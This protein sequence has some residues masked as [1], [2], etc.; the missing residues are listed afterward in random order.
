MTHKKEDRRV[1]R[2]RQLLREALISLILE[3]RYETI[4]V[5]DILD[6]ANVGRSTFYA[7]FP[8]KEALL[9]SSFYE[10]GQDLHAH[11]I[12]E[13]EQLKE[14]EGISCLHLFRHAESNY[15]LYKAMMGGKGIDVVVETGTEYM[16]IYL[17]E[18]IKPLTGN[19]E[20]QVP[21][22]V[23]IKYLTG[24]LMSLLR[25]WL[26]ND[27]P[28][29]PEKMDEMFQQIAMPGVWNVLEVGSKE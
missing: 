22:L 27:M 21:M 16:Q 20:P 13:V 25:W 18:Q 11:I 4:T 9:L 29:S 17:Q 12:E 5:Q 8:D 1:Q 24:A 6:R 15:P 14:A 3:Q 2:T 28:H 23:L 19:N 7:H 10:L 26:D